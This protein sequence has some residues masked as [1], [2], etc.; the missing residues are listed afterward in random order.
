MDHEP[1]EGTRNTTPALP[2]ALETRYN[3]RIMS[4]VA[5]QLRQA[6]E[7]QHLTVEQVAEIT[8]IR[9]DHLR[10]LEEGNFDV[11]SAPVY[12]KGF[13]R[14]LSTL[15]KLN[16]PQMMAA[17]DDELGKTKQ[18]AEPPP[19]SPHSHGFLDFV[20][21]QMSKVDWQ[22][23]VWVLGTLIVTATILLIVVISR[24]SRTADP[25][26]GV[27]P[28]MYKSTRTNAGETLPL[29]PAKR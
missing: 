19:L 18:F 7:A 21:L 5:E 8:K 24:N 3:M 4:T 27:K 6:R 13:V 1:D 10:A 9:T 16:V 15:L 28:A 14:S 2:L 25:L 12:I 22:K 23:G 29:P 11:F 26:K 17:L 20:M